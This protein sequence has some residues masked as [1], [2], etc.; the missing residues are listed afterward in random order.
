[1]QKWFDSLTMKQVYFL[2]FLGVCAFPFILFFGL[3]LL[4]VAPWIY[5]ELGS[6]IS[7]QDRS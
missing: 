7:K 3:G 2:R 4:Y 5:L 6:K 1:M